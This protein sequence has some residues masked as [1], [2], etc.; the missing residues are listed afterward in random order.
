MQGSLHPSETLEK[1][2]GKE[3]NLQLAIGL[4]PVKGFFIAIR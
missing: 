4:C 3:S 1:R 2:L